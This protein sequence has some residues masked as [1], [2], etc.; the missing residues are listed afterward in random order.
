MPCIWSYKQLKIYIREEQKYYRK[1]LRTRD[2]EYVQV[3]AK[4]LTGEKI[5]KITL[6]Q[7]IDEWLD[8]REPIEL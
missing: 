3:R 2:D 7:V 5:F 1:S 6:W 8:D 4:R